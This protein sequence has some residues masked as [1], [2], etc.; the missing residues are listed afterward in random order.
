MKIVHLNEANGNWDA[1][2]IVPGYIVA[3]SRDDVLQAPFLETNSFK[4]IKLSL[5]L[6]NKRRLTEV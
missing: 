6:R 5:Y 1:R 4:T 3:Q 2:P